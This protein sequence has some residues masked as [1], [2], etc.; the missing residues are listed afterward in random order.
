M[1]D[2]EYCTVLPLLVGKL[3]VLV[4]IQ[5]WKSY[6]DIL[7]RNYVMWSPVIIISC[8]IENGLTSSKGIIFLSLTA[9]E[10]LVVRLKGCVK[11]CFTLYAQSSEWYAQVIQI[12]AN[13]KQTTD[14]SLTWAS[15]LINAIFWPV[16]G[17][18][19]L[20]KSIYK[21]N[22]LLITLEP[23]Y[24]TR[25]FRLYCTCFIQSVIHLILLSV[26]TDPRLF[27]VL[28]YNNF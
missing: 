22:M 2:K 8:F 11:Y 28:H 26:L 13:P 10:F 24:V 7:S 1:K 3:N 25:L 12:S 19:D 20:K 17:I 16:L 27:S 21:D 5:C 23:A 9:T 18:S 4:S 15:Y 14:H 6:T